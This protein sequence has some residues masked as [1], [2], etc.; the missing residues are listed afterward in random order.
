[1]MTA[2]T[3]TE[4]IGNKGEIMDVPAIVDPFFPTP[5]AQIQDKYQKILI[6]APP[7]VNI[8]IK[9]FNSIVTKPKGII[10]D[11]MLLPK[12]ADVK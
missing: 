3:T 7:K 1:M 9:S 2:A 4:A 11:Q 6:I 5:P 12:T 10:E 8:I